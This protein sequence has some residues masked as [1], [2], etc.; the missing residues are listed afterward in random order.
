MQRFKNWVHVYLIEHLKPT[1]QPCR[2]RELASGSRKVVRSPAAGV[3]PSDEFD[4][5]IFA[6]ERKHDE[7]DTIRSKCIHSSQQLRDRQSSKK[8]L[9][10]VCLV[11][12]L[13]RV[14]SPD[15]VQ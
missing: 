11:M 10:F 6:N 14:G 2:G 1:T 12:E 3:S 4:F 15:A 5:C 7:T 8:E 9:G 13:R